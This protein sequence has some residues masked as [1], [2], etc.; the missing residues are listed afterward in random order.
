MANYE[1]AR[2]KLTN[3]QLKKFQN[4]RLGQHEESHWQT[5]KMNN[6]HM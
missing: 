6:C 2:V 5:F 3:N 4:V 1:D